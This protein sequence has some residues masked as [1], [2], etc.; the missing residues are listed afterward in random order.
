[1]E[2]PPRPA[3]FEL[4]LALIPALAG[5]AYATVTATMNSLTP[6]RRVA[7]KESLTGGSRRALE[8]YLS[9]PD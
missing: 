2:P 7:L 6:A 1:M 9:D 8:R 3:E 5:A 4:L